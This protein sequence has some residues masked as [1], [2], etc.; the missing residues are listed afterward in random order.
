ML[1]IS[2]AYKKYNTNA[3]GKTRSNPPLN[4]P[5]QVV[6]DFGKK[7]LL[8]SL[9][10]RNSILLCWPLSYL[11]PRQMSNPF[12]VKGPNLWIN[13]RSPFPF[14][15]LALEFS[16]ENSVLLSTKLLLVTLGD[17]ANL[18]CE[19]LFKWERLALVD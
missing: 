9:N 1:K 18:V 4:L 19:R 13:T 2:G 12:S 17:H 7:Y 11:K 6:S 5:G 15:N 16:S 14:K 8:A 3:S 10:A